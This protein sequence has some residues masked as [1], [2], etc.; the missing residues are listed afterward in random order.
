V[1]WEQISPDKTWGAQSHPAYTGYAWYRKHLH[2]TPA[3][4]ASSDFALLIQHIDDVYEI[5]WNGV[6]VGHC[7]TMPPNFLLPP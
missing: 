4:G 5:Y 1:G 6:L 3:P 7:G 2:L